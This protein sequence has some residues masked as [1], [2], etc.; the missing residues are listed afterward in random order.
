MIDIAMQLSGYVMAPH[1]DE[2][3]KEMRETFKQ[4]QLVRAKLYAVT[5]ILEPSVS[6]VI[7][8]S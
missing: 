2:E 1:T 7:E 8:Y 5:K 4:N 6:L 3:A